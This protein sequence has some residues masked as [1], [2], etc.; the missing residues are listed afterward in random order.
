MSNSAREK[1][2]IGFDDPLKLGGCRPGRGLH[3]VQSYVDA[4]AINE[5]HAG[6]E[7]P[8]GENPATIRARRLAPGTTLR[9]TPCAAILTPGAATPYGVER[10]SDRS[11]SGFLIASLKVGSR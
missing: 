3:R 8:R 1:K 10:Q 2:R 9:R 6:A 7:N 11:A 4:G 5:R